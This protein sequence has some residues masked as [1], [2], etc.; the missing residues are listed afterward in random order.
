[1]TR[2][3]GVLLTAVIIMLSGC[4]ALNYPQ[5]RNE[6]THNPDIEK[7][8]FVVHRNLN[9]VV[10]SLDKQSKACINRTVRSGSVSSMSVDGY[11]MVIKRVSAS[12]A[13]LTYRNV[14]NNGIGQPEGGYYLFAADMHAAG[15]S[16]SVT[17]YHGPMEDKL[18]DAVEAWAKGD[19]NSCHGYGG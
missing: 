13:E 19:V 17:F 7:K 5:S 10:A 14:S 12:K 18:M 6:F 16:T 3:I 2:W 15:S 4:G 8:H 1:M 9:A 11:Y